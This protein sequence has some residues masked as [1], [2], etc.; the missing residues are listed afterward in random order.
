[1][2]KNEPG[3]WSGSE[4]GTRNEMDH[5]H[6]PFPFYSPRFRYLHAKIESGV[7]STCVYVKIRDEGEQRAR[8][9]ESMP[10]LSLLPL[11]FTLLTA[12]FPLSFM[13]PNM[14]FIVDDAWKTRF[15]GKIGKP[16]RR[17][18]IVGFVVAMLLF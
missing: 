10:V 13:L 15:E 18:S 17:S 2:R 16:P 4:S 9:Q 6:P 1:M 5:V 14:L 8:I 3:S 12:C 7:G 11:I